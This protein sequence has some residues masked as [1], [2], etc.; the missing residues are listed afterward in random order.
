[1]CHKDGL[2]EEPVCRR[3]ENVGG[4][5]KDSSTPPPLTDIYTHTRTHMDLSSAIAPNLV[6]QKDD[7]H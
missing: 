1:M 2:R 5:E 3:G 4:G 7:E 6:V